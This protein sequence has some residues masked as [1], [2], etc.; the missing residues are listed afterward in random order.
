MRGLGRRRAASQSAKS[1]RVTAGRPRS[2]LG[3]TGPQT[4]RWRL[5]AAGRTPPRAVAMERKAR[6]KTEQRAVGG[7]AMRHAWLMATGAGRAGL[8]AAGERQD[9]R[10]KRLGQRLVNQSCRVCTPKRAHPACNTGRFLSGDSLGRPGEASVS[11]R[12]SKR[13]AAHARLKDSLQPAE[14]DADRAYSHRTCRRLG[15]PRP[16]PAR[17]RSGP[18][19]LN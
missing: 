13:H 8:R 6:Q 14:I 9:R 5:A 18:G 12:L 15:R 19:R 1:G 11:A 2:A 4:R 7:D 10:P 16:A 17:A 3:L